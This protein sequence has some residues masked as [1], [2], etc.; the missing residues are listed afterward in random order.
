MQLI[1]TQASQLARA[2]SDTNAVATAGYLNA[3]K[4]NTYQEEVALSPTTTNAELLALVNDYAGYLEGTITWQVPVIADDGT[5]EVI[6][7]CPVWRPTDGTDPEVSWGLWI[8]NAGTTVAYFMGQF[9]GAPLSMADAN[10]S[11]SVVIR[12]RPA[13]NSMVVV[14]S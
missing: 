7:T 5:V 11:I 8:S 3:A 13:T 6:G 12:Y 1:E 14:I 4:I 2:L 9:D 10:N